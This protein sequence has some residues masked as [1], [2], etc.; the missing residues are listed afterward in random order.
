M[1]ATLL[2]K[3]SMNGDCRKKKP[4]KELTL[5]EKVQLIRLASNNPGL[6]Q[7]SMAEK[8]E[9]AKSNVCRILQRKNEYLRAFES[10]G[11][12]G[13]RKRKLRS[14]TD[15]TAMI[16]SS[17]IASTSESDCGSDRQG[18]CTSQ[19]SK[20]LLLFIIVSNFW[21]KILFGMGRSNHYFIFLFNVT[22][23][24]P[25]IFKKF[26]CEVCCICCSNLRDATGTVIYETH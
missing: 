11:F 6:S 8:Y 3:S 17:R 10:A 5:E 2:V 25:A 9:I 14:D 15:I 19:L 20:I 22:L 12:S 23:A 4:Y 16:E 18:N 21:G 7:A 24:H 26:H 1:T 13:S